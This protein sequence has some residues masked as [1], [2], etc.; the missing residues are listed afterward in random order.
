[1]QDANNQQDIVGFIWN[2]A[3]KLRGP[4]RPPQ[5]RKVMIPMVVLR[6]LDLVLAPTKEAVLA[7]HARL[8][9]RGMAGPALESALSR[10]AL[11]SDR[12]QPLYNISQFTLPKL[13]RLTS[14]KFFSST[15]NHLF[16]FLIT[17]LS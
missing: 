7:E 12:R 17:E 11:G 1:M 2:I 14:E 16:I 6:R 9:A 10:V 3:N 5:Y 4:Y 15:K 8:T 13:H